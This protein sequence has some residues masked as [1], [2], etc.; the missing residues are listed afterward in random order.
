M[1]GAHP[2]GRRAEDLIADLIRLRGATCAT[3]G[4]GLCGHALLF[5]FVLGNKAV[6][7]CAACLATTV[8]RETRDLERQLASYVAHR[9]CYLGAWRWST[10][11]EGACPVGAHVDDDAEGGDDD[12]EDETGLV[13]LAA[14]AR[15]PAVAATWDAGGMSCGDLV[16]ELRGRML[17]LPPRAI[18]AVTALDPGAPVDLPAWCRL[19]RNRLVHVRLPEFF[20]QRKED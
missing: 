10:L 9:D 3:C 2:S 19:T 11:V 5:A 13:A 16:M 20:I 14:T 15:P 1:S 8:E 6:P 12:A 4:V 18:L 7:R 17:A